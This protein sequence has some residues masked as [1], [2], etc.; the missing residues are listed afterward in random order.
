MKRRFVL[1][2]LQLSYFMAFLQCSQLTKTKLGQNEFRKICRYIFCQPF[3]NSSISVAKLSIESYIVIRTEAVFKNR[4]F[5]DPDV[6]QFN[7]L[8]LNFLNI[9]ALETHL[10]FQD[11]AKEILLSVQAGGKVKLK[12]QSDYFMMPPAF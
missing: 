9:S 12:K 3:V 10:R 2:T 4:T 11:R 8:V 7:Y 1:L 6:I 5:F